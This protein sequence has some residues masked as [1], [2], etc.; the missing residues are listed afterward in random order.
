[1]RAGDHCDCQ[2]TSHT[3]LHPSLPS[4]LA[5][6]A[7]A[8]SAEG[9]AALHALAACLQSLG[10]CE[11]AEGCWQREVQLLSEAGRPDTEPQAMAA[12]TSFAACLYGKVRRM[13]LRLAAQLICVV[14]KQ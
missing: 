4:L 12:L 8:S 6:S 2:C 5:R 1:M 13:S 14:S 7:G 9:L 11:E 3:A 10:L